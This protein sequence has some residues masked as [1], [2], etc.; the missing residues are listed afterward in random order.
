MYK[1]TCQTIFFTIFAEISDISAKQA[2]LIALDLEYFAYKQFMG[3]IPL[4]E[5]L[6]HSNAIKIL[7]TLFTLFQHKL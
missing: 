5:R 6:F 1:K 2:N 4:E 7:T 3:N